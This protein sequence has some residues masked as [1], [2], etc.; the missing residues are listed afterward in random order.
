MGIPMAACTE[1]P[2]QNEG[3]EKNQIN[4]HTGSQRLFGW[5]SNNNLKGQRSQDQAR[6]GIFDLPNDLGNCIELGSQM[7]LDL[8]FDDRTR[9]Q[10]AV[11]HNGRLRICQCRWHV[12][13]LP[14]G[15]LINLKEEFAM[16]AGRDFQGI[17]MHF[18]FW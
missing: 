4:K 1:C 6:L 12:S 5:L 10:N 9:V 16:L 8:A 13:D 2:M 11:G 3:S 14:V 15:N 17:A 7:V 18:E